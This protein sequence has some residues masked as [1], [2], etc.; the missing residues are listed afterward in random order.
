[1]PRHHSI[2]SILIAVGACL[3]PAMAAFASENAICIL[4][5]RV[6]EGG[7]WAPRLP[8]LSLLD[9]RG[10]AVAGA[11]AHALAQVRQVRVAAATPLTRCDGPGATLATGPDLP[12][13]RQPVP[14]LTAGTTPI[15][16]VAVHDL[17]SR[18]GNWVELQ[19]TPPADRRATA[20]R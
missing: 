6:G 18:L 2:A 5:G 16:V 7:R 20:T 12:G 14:I 9:A 15:D 19:V 10:S 17:R 13:E 3:A 4:A 8:G 1:M 11:S